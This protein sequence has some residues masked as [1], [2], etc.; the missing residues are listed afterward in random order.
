MWL[1]IHVTKSSPPRFLPFRFSRSLTEADSP[2][3]PALL[4]SVEFTFETM[5]QAVFQGQVLETRADKC[6]E[7]R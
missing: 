1:M 2:G 6:G 4:V 7:Q 3:K 5:A